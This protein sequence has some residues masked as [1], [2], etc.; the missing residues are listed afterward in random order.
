MY[1]SQHRNKIIFIYRI[2]LL[3]SHIDLYSI[4]ST[5]EIVLCDARSSDATKEFSYI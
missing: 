1:L 3:Y 5:I 2:K 4:P